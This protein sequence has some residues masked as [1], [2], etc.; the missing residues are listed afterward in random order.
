MMKD[1][2]LLNITVPVGSTPVSI[3]LDFEDKTWR[4]EGGPHDTRLDQSDFPI[5]VH[6]D[7][8]RLE[9]YSNGTFDEV[10]DAPQQL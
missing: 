5:P 9:L 1:A 8:V 10:E 6:V 3:A 4:S 7:D 2:A